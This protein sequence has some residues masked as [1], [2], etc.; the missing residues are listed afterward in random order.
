[1]Y[2]FYDEY[3]KTQAS[4]DRLRVLPDSH[5]TVL[6]DFSSNDY[7]G[8]SRH[9]RLIDAVTAAATQWGAGST[10]SRLLS[11]NYGLIE[12]LENQIAQDKKTEAALI[13]STGYQ[14]NMTVLASL[15]STR[16]LPAAPLV[17]FD[18]LNHSSLYN[19]LFLSKADYVTYEHNDMED[20]RRKLHEHRDVSRP[21]FIVAE[22]VHGMEGD[23][24]PLAEIAALAKEYECFLYLDEAHA[25]GLYGDQGFGL[26]TT[27]DLSD[28][29][30]LVMGTFSK[31]LGG[32]GAYIAAT[33]GLKQFFL[34]RT[35]GFI[36][37]TAPAPVTVAAAYEAWKMVPELHAQRDRLFTLARSLRSK[38]REQGFTVLGDGSNI[39]PVC[40]HQEVNTLGLKNA[41]LADGILVS[42]IRPPTVPTGTSR[43]RI[44]VNATHDESAIAALAASMAKHLPNTISESEPCESL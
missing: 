40:L 29:P 30:H 4:K 18:R 38:L 22:T 15:L 44:A 20:L 42:A 13:F 23:L 2:Q 32:Q 1:M 26:S 5:A 16:V 37:S 36:Y 41:L 10:G 12:S 34:N 14:A 7:L 8:L 24:L 33:H 39:V 25:T 6:H 3:C 9:P 28:V 17:F 11:G 19:G 21:S 31:A 43:L 27:V 35:A